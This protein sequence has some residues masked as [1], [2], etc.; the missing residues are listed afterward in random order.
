MSDLPLI[1]V[2]GTSAPWSLAWALTVDGLLPE[3]PRAVSHRSTLGRAEGTPIEGRPNWT[4]PPVRLQMQRPRMGNQMPGTRGIVHHVQQKTKNV[5]MK[6]SR[7]QRGRRR[8][9]S[10]NDNVVPTLD[11]LRPNGAARVSFL[12]EAN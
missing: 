3:L 6:G 2:V 8:T 11:C 9:G 1:P 7:R 5:S 10:Q 4:H 12:D